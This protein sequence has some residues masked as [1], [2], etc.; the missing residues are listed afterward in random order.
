M[1]KEQ[2]SQLTQTTCLHSHGCVILAA[3]CSSSTHPTWTNITESYDKRDTIHTQKT[4]H[5]SRRSGAEMHTIIVLRNRRQEG[6]EHGSR[7]K[8]RARDGA[9]ER[10]EKKRK[11][12]W[13]LL[14][15]CFP[16]VWDLQPSS[17][18]A[19]AEILQILAWS[20]RYSV[21]GTFIA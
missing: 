20:A 18:C 21:R 16:T 5:H 13:L 4:I 8:I 17:F 15:P 1:V 14:L 19:R 12:P 11:R 10:E 2:L 9:G 6:F 7:G 3:K